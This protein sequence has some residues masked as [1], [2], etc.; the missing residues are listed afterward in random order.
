MG[1][2]RP[3][4]PPCFETGPFT[5]LDLSSYTSARTPASILPRWGYRCVPPCLAFAR[6]L[7]MLTQALEF[8][9]R[10]PYRQMLLPRLVAEDLE[11]GKL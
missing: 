2:Q 10:V 6:V 4:S 7:G 5:D 8:V 1:E 11:K 9:Q 3:Q